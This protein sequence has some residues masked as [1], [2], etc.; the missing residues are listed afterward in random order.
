MDI[1]PTSIR[2]FIY[3]VPTGASIHPHTSEFN[4]TW[5][6]VKSG[7]FQRA[8]RVLN[9]RGFIKKADLTFK[10]SSSGCYST[11]AYPMAANNILT[12]DRMV[13]VAALVVGLEFDFA[14]LLISIIH[15][16]PVVFTNSYVLYSS[17]ARML[18]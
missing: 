5:A 9:P 7:K 11:S 15:K 17:Y 1:S 6:L 14:K 10:A 12:W 4:Y 3:G 13:L 16:R 2:R 18:K 8:D